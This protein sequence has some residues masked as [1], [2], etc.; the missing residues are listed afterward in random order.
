MIVIRGFGTIGACTVGAGN[1][2]GTVDVVQ[3]VFNASGAIDVGHR[4]GI[5]SAGVVYRGFNGEKHCE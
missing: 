1:G 4:A 5:G 2:F 3:M